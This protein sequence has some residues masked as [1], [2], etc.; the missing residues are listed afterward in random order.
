[1]KN[2][3]DVAAAV[4]VVDGKVFAARRK[5]GLHLAGC[6][7]FPG[8]KVESGETPE[9]C[10]FR[11]LREELSI[12]T[13]VGQYIGENLHDYGSKIVRLIAFQVEHVEGDI[14]LVEHD[15]LRWLAVEEL[16]SIDW[17]PADIPIVELYRKLIKV[18]YTNI[19]HKTS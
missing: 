11:E 15:E 14:Q 19:A 5:L 1:M 12:I 8:G 3:I 6:W 13:K 4:I 7:E 9:Q 16:D 18:P 17:A 10:L 2:P